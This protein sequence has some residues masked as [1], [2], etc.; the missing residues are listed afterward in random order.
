MNKKVILQNMSVAFLAQ[1]VSMALSIIQTLIVPK[2]LGVEQYGY[3]QLYIFY[4][5][6]VGF[7]HLGLSSGVYLSTGGQTREKMDKPAIKSQMI[8]GVTYQAVMA[9]VIVVLSSL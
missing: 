3:W 9:A 8:F 1:G 5:S 7:F 4:V 2:L 6:Y